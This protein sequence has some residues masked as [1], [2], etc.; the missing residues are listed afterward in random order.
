M[1]TTRKRSLYGTSI[2][3][4]MLAAAYVFFW[5]NGARAE[6]DPSRL[7]AVERDTMIRSV[8]AVG[9]IEPIGKV[10]IKSKANG[11]IEALLVDVGARVT[12]GQVLAELDKENVR[13]R[14]REARANLQAAGAAVTGAEAQLAK[15]IVEAEGPDVEFA[16]RTYERA[17]NLF[18]QDLLPHSAL[19]EARSALEVAENRRQAA[20]AAM[21]VARARI[22][23]AQANAAQA[24]AAVERVQ[25]ELAN[26]TLRAPIAG[27]VLTRDVEVGSPVSSILNL[28]A[29]A[30]LVMTLGDISEVFV[31][32]RVDEVDVGRVHEGQRAVIRV[33]TFK[34][35]AFDGVVTQIAPIG[36]ERDNVTTFEVRVSIA[37]PG[38]ELKA[39]M[40]ANAEVVLEEMPDSL[41]IPEAAI[42]YDAQR[43][44]WVEV[45]AA[46]EPGGRRRVPVRTGYGTGTRTQILEGLREGDKVILPS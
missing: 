22:S 16:R 2:V 3:L 36:S 42:S 19:D 4:A 7:A 8:V 21:S 14:L 39:N 28:G 9:R 27:T 23:E 1:T 31:R 6:F 43:T 26:A 40:T 17:Q 32:G 38:S 33:E 29:N 18:E 20:R 37:N 30:T 41:I 34:D 12:T 45:P 15:T 10:E 35:R 25:E 24:K 44:P 46:G 5:G 13:A 11:I